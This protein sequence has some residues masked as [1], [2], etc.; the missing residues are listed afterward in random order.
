M[1]PF[2]G[3]G[4]I[5]QQDVAARNLARQEITRFLG[6]E[7]TRANAMVDYLLKKIADQS[8]AAARPAEQIWN[9]IQNSP[10]LLPVRARTDANVADYPEFSGWVAGKRDVIER[11]EKARLREVLDP[12][13]QQRRFAN[14]VGL[15]H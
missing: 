10:A 15:L 3:Y 5:A 6:V 14:T 7:A 9:D 8:K 1:T 2:N 12:L 4:R 11:Q 13:E